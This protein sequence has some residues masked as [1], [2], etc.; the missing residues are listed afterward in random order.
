MVRAAFEVCSS[1]I[2]GDDPI[3]PTT[4]NMVEIYVFSRRTAFSLRIIKISLSSDSW[5]LDVFGDV[6]GN[7]AS[8]QGWM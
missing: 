2:T 1:P 4:S 8:I 7:H 6:G 3:I 5:F